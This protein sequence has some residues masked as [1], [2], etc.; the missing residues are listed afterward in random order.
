MGEVCN[1]V[2]KWEWEGGKEGERG[3][4]KERGRMRERESSVLFI[5][6]MA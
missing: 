5:N 6:V 4:G 1:V 3:G 2:R